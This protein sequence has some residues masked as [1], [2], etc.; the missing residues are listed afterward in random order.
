MENEILLDKSYVQGQIYIITN[1]ITQKKYI[2]QTLTHRKNRGKYRPFGFQG[3]F[4]D[5]LSEAICN[6]KKKQCRYLNNAI[7]HYGKEAFSV[8]L[9][10]NCEIY[11]LDENESYYIKA[12]NTL[13]PNG[14]N[15]TRGGKTVEFI[16]G[17]DISK[18]E[19][20]N[21]SKRGGCLLRTEKTRNRISEQLKKVLGTEENRK[22][23][24]N[25]TKEQH[26]NQKYE[27]FKGQTI[28]LEKLDDYL[29]IKH[30]KGIPFVVVKVNKKQTSF[31]GKFQNIDELKEQAKE[32]LREIA[33]LS[34]TSSN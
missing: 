31:V 17:E 29:Y 27:R 6:T 2:G 32:F 1:N 21:P 14:Y 10:T 23:Q 28:D 11:E 19:I 7:R 15:L 12:Y 3:R 25:V 26:K 33:K 4:N 34:A 5:H 9:I 20:N 24:M 18:L 22:K 8:A 13:Y 30:A 16:T